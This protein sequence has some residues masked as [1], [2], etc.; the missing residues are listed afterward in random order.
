M[1]SVDNTFKIKYSKRCF[2]VFY[3]VATQEEIQGLFNKYQDSFS[4]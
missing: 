2:I 3:Q 1:R 4:R